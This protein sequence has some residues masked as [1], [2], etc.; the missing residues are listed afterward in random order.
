M[1]LHA[2][3]TMMHGLKPG[4]YIFAMTSHQVSTGGPNVAVVIKPYKMY[5]TGIKSDRFTF[6]TDN[7]DPSCGSYSTL[8]YN[9]YDNVV[10]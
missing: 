4:E 2:N 6:S 3:V 7:N 9:Y 10:K 1:A 8:H 5:Y